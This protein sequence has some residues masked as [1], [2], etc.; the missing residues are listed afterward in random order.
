MVSFSYYPIQFFK[1]QQSIKWHQQ[2]IYVRNNYII[3]SECQQP[4]LHGV[5]RAVCSAQNNQEV[6]V[7][8]SQTAHFSLKKT[9][10]FRHC[11]PITDI[12]TPF[13]AN[14][15]YLLRA[16]AC[17]SI[18]RNYKIIAEIQLRNPALTTSS[19]RQRHVSLI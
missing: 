9:R 2:Y 16:A 14:Q 6:G 12:I 11:I 15:L 4:I 3:R 18:Q 10:S 17:N 13:G 19:R 5:A 8:N 1:L 7:I